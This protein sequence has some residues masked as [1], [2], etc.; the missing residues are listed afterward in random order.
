MA[1]ENDKWIRRIAAWLPRLADPADARAAGEALFEVSCAL[2]VS[3][4]DQ[5]G[6][7]TDDPRLSLHAAAANTLDD[8]DRLIPAWIERL[9]I[10]LRDT[11]AHSQRWTDAARSAADVDGESADFDLAGTFV[12]PALISALRA[13]GDRLD[14]HLDRIV[15]AMGE[16]SRDADEHLAQAL[17][18]AG[19]GIARATPALMKALRLRG[20]WCWPSHL[21]AA[22]AR[23]ATYDESILPQLREMLTAGDDAQRR[24]A[25]DIIGALGER[26]REAADELLAFAE[27]DPEG[28]R[29]SALSALARQ[30]PPAP[31][32]L[33]LLE[34]GFHDDSGYVRRAAAH[35]AGELKADPDRFVPLLIAACNQTMHLHDEDL[36]EAAVRALGSYGPS[37]RDA[38]KRLR[39][40]IDGPVEER[41]VGIDLVT[42]ALRRIAGEGAA[43]AEV[44]VYVP[45]RRQT[46]P[47]DVEPLWAVTHRGRLCYVDRKGQL[48]IET[49]FT[50]GT[51]FGDG[52]AI[53][54]GDDATV[55]IDRAGRVVF[56]SDWDDI[57]PF[58]EGL[59]AVARRGRWGFVDT[60]GRVV[61][62]PRFSSVTRF[63]EGLAGAE[64]GR[65]TE[66]LGKLITRDRP[67]RRGFIDRAGNVVI[68]LELEDALPF[69]EGLAV[70]CTGSTLRPSLLDENTL[71]PA[72]HKYGYID[73]SGRLVIDGR[74]DLA[75]GFSEGLAAVT[76]GAWRRRERDGYI[77]PSGREVIPL[78]FTS[79]TC[80]RDGVAVVRRRGRRWRGVQ[81]V[82]D[83]AGNVLL[84]TRHLLLEGF[85]EGLAAA[86]ID[87]AYGVIDLNGRVVVKPGFDSIGLFR[88]GLAAVS[89]GDWHGLIDRDG[90]FVWG[91]TRE[92]LGNGGVIES[93]WAD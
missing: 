51:P 69:S 57:R 53:V 78:E 8:L 6:R 68:A 71:V 82:I 4:S 33:A 2:S 41:T 28:D 89:R 40:F 22:L 74:Y 52:R 48:V 11:Q 87:D 60:D 10:T 70:V 65:T 58:H 61:I 66:K 81:F 3:T 79:S 38:I 31:Q 84:E 59:A 16:I 18:G 12:T 29:I 43:E 83:T 5:P 20:I 35:I 90:R 30:G 55:V 39:R 15:A 91:P 47:D 75:S 64:L 54:Y 19:P 27:R 42:D 73:R 1:T 85:S 72:E 7:D 13:V 92:A 49:A 93:E 46:T 36:P 23:A 62:E 26:G 77:D 56:E 45:Q 21:V 32:T 63:S 44:A 25:A 37:A 50:H 76:R 24:A 17:L 14:P 86:W 34:R 9:L 80:F 67:G 88:D